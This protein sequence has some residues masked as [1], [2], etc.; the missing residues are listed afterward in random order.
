MG[1]PQP[2]RRP[3]GHGLPVT[4]AHACAQEAT[5]RCD[6]CGDAYCPDQRG[7]R[8]ARGRRTSLLRGL[9]GPCQRYAVRRGLS[10]VAGRPLRCERGDVVAARPAAIP[11]GGV[12][13]APSSPCRWPRP[14][15]CRRRRRPRRLRVRQARRRH[16]SRPRHRRR[17][18]RRQRFS[19]RY[20]TVT[21]S[22]VSRRQTE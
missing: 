20:K 3:S 2:A 16:P 14:P 9:P 11:A 19:T 18:R 22:R 13:A 6:R 8:P 5:Q 17:S 1:E 12:Y 4:E 7:D 10:R 21:R 15:H